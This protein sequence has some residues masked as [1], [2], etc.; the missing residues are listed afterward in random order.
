MKTAV[1][2]SG[3]LLCALL[4]ACHSP[5]QASAGAPALRSEREYAEQTEGRA[6]DLYKTGQASSIADARAQAAGEA[7]QQWYAAAKARERQADQD[8]FEKD[9]KKSQASTP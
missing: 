6:Q 9:F 3:L 7:N 4:A 1:P 2:V 5:H 8:K